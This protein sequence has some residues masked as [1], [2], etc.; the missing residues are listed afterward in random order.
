MSDDKLIE[1][2]EHYQRNLNR[3]LKDDNT[4]KLLHCI[5]KLSNLPITVGHLE[6]TG[7]GRTVNAMRKMEGKV[8]DASREL[9]NK[10]KL[11]VSQNQ[12]CDDTNKNEPNGKSDSSHRQSDKSKNRSDN[13]DSESENTSSDE[14]S[15]ESENDDEEDEN[16]SDRYENVKRHKSESPPREKYKSHHHHHKKSSKDKRYK[17]YDRK[18]KEYK[19]KKDKSP[20]R[21]PEKIK[22][23]KEKDRFKS[24]SSNKRKNEVD[25][26]RSHSKKHKSHHSKED[27]NVN[28][29]K[30]IKDKSRTESK[31]KESNQSL[32]SSQLVVK[33]SKKESK[34][35]SYDKKSKSKEK[36][37]KKDERKDEK[38]DER[39]D[40]KKHSIKKESKSNRNEN[41]ICSESGTSFADALGMLEPSTSKST[42]I[43]NSNKKIKPERSIRE[44]TPEKSYRKESLDKEDKKEKK[45]EKDRVST[46]SS[47]IEVVVP[48]PPP[49]NDVDIN[50]SSLLPMITPNYRPLANPLYDS[51]QNLARGKALNDDEALSLVMSQKNQRT[52]VYSGNKMFFNSIPSLFELCIRVLQD[53]IDALEYTGGVPYAILKPVLDKASPQQLYTMEHY[54][55]YLIE[56]TDELWQF[57][58]SKDFKNKRREELESWREMYMRC[59]DEREAKLK[60]LT[61][62][63]KVAQEKSTPVRQTKLAYIDSFVKPPRDVIRKQAKN[64]IDKKPLITPQSRLNAIAAGSSNAQVSVPNPVRA[65]SNNSSGAVKPKKAPLMQKTLAFLKGGRFR[66]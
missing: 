18:E 26:E 24:N 36:D 7:V 64:G 56:D 66:R 16:D 32:N 52:K 8:G 22:S 17:D 28:E 43:T 15:S 6:E 5:F 60:A 50:I 27:E 53:N 51:M 2:I 46:S 29:S 47:K 21:S 59:L 11:M 62:N 65:S 25:N 4:A 45:K 9:V 35:E 48:P 19:Y 33:E 58:C 61:E 57:H 31:H 20:S 40:E 1:A 3:G 13:S 63:I 39:K 41:G 10:W 42:I 14:K 37:E 54:N 12:D 49:K 38:K 30:R 44:K 23:N 34:R 55:P